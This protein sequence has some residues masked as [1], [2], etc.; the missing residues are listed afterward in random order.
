MV[1]LTPQEKLRISDK[2][3][4]STEGILFVVWMYFPSSEFQLTK[5]NQQFFKL[6]N[7]Y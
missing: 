6:R 2:A 7:I 5:L 4:L 1:L 3:R